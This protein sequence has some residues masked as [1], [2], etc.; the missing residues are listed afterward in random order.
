MHKFS[1]VIPFRDRHEHISVL[2]P[3]LRNHASKNNLD[4]E[5]IVVEQIG[6]AHV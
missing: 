3:H 5:I 4:L 1:V 6:R 2:V